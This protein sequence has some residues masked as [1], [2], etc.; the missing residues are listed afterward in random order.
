MEK[1]LFWPL[2]LGTLFV[3]TIFVSQTMAAEFH[4]TNAT[5]FQNALNTASDNGQDDTIHLAAGIYQGTSAT[6]HL[7][8]NTNL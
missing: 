1:R 4:V 3:A 2:R 6:L 7:V 5:E 8:L